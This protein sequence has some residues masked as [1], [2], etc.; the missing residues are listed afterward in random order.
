MALLFFILSAFDWFFSLLA[1]EVGVREGNPFLAWC[2]QNSLFTPAKWALTIVATCLILSLYRYRS[3][4][5][6]AYCG[7]LLMAL[8]TGYH[9]VGL[10]AY[11]Y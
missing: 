1:F 2:Q 6:V 8:M 11:L 10:Q 4:R 5:I 9:I 3:G 7:V